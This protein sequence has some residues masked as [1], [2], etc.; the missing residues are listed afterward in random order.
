[1][2]T[3]SIKE[4]E[5]EIKWYLIDAKGVRLGKIATTAAELLMG[6]ADVN[7]VDYQEP[8]NK[9]VIINC[10]EFDVFAKKLKLKMY[11]S[12]S[13]FPGGFKE[14]TLEQMMAKSPE[15][16]IRLAIKR[17]LPQNRMG[18]KMYKNL[19][20]IKGPN[21]KLEAQQPTEVKIK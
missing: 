4:K 13:G 19:N 2:K 7:R 11:H 20:V 5:T 18:N 6:K 8:K 1:M 3:R 9:V 17:M 12:H 16:V 14:R 10:E 15:K 21:H